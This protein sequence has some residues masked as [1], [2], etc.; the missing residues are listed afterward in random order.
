MSRLAGWICRCCSCAIRTKFSNAKPKRRAWSSTNNSHVAETRPDQP[1]RL[2]PWVI[3]GH[4]FLFGG[5]DFF[6]IDRLA[7]SAFH[8]NHDVVD[9][10]GEQFRRFRA[11][12]RAEQ[13]IRG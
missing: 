1:R 6:Q 10:L 9:A 4:R 3:G 2:N 13:P 11:K 5:D 8:R 7:L 12:A